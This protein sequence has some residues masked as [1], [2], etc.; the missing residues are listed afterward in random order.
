MKKKTTKKKVKVPVDV[1]PS[2][3]VSHNTFT[4]VQWDK[5]SL[6][7]IKTVAEGLTNLT[8]L[9]KSQNVEIKN[10]LSIHDPK[11]IIEK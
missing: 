4:G 8:N 3:T 6:E 1:R 11:E 7:V 9:F 10:M 2:I 5:S